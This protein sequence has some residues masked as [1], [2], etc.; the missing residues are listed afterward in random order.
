[1]KRHIRDNIVNLPYSIH[2]G[3][4]TAFEITG[5]KLT[6]KFK[7]GFIK[8]N[9]FMQVNGSIEIEEIDWDFTNVYL[10][11]YEGGICSNI[12][13][14]TGR[15]MDLRE[16]ANLYKNPEFTLIDETYGYNTS[17]FA[18]FIYDRDDFIECMIEIYHLG[19]MYYVME[20]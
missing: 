1:M 13:S 4:V 11:E 3:V 20:E 10:I 5:D 2:D 18:G 7:E 14:F 12:G 9:P 17:K 16:F 6:M 15:K 8:I 19:D